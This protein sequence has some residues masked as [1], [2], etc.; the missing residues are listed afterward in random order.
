M[1]SV[2]ER[3]EMKPRTD[4]VGVQSVWYAT[5]SDA[6]DRRSYLGLRDAEEREE[7]HDGQ[8]PMYRREAAANP[9]C[10]C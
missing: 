7:G 5:G 2:A 4:C 6:C 8:S 3:R 9:I 10:R 1:S